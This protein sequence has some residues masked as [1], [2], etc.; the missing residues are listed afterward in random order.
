MS[1][2]YAQGANGSDVKEIQAALN[3]HIRSSG[4]PLRPDGIFGPLTDARTKEFQK[5][6]RL[7]M[8]GLIGPKTLGAFYKGIRGVSEIDL[9]PASLLAGPGGRGLSMGSGFAPPTLQISNTG[10]LQIPKPAKYQIKRP[11]SV[12]FDIKTQLVLDPLAD[13]KKAPKIKYKLT[14]THELPWPVLLPKPAKLSFDVTNSPLTAEY[15]MSAKLKV[16][17][18]EMPLPPFALY[19]SGS[20]KPYFFTGVGV[21]QH[22]FGKFNA[23]VGAALKIKL[24]EPVHHPYLPTVSVSADG[25]YKFDVKLGDGKVE[26]KGFFQGVLGL[27]WHVF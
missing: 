17:F 14:L 8:D 6:A 3:F 10:P 25:G 5:A 27:E 18:V 16:P 4:V 13:G 26:G 7:A 22:G 11:K 1:K 20:L 19:K 9:T 2:L 24:I 23:G 12:G 15:S 21:Q